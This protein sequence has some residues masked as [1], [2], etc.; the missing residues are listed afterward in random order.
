[1]TGGER[2]R[3]EGSSTVRRVGLVDAP[4]LIEGFP[5]EV[6]FG[7][8][9]RLLSTQ[10]P[11]E[12]RLVL[13]RIPRASALDL[14]RRAG[15]V[16]ETELMAPSGN[17]GATPAELS[18]EAESAAEL[19]RRVAENDPELWR[20][21][22]GFHARGPSARAAERWRDELARRGLRLRFRFRRPL[23]EAALVSAAPR[24]SG[25]EARPNGYWHTLHT[26]GVA[27][28]FPFV[29]EA[30]TE[31]GGVLVGLLLEDAAPVFLDRFRHASFSWGV[32]G[33][34]GSGKSFFA[35][36]AAL[37]T[38]WMRP[39]L[40]LV[41]LD[42]LGEF[43]PLVRQL[44]GTV[45]SLARDGT[46]R[47]NPL[48]PATTAGD[49]EEKAARVGAMLRALFPSL[50]DEEVATLDS[51]LGATLRAGGEPT[52][53]DLRSAVERQGTPGRL[54]TLLE[55]FRTGSLRYLN[56]PSTVRWGDGPVAV[57][58]SGAPDS[59]LAFHLAYVLD[60]VLGRL[61]TRPGPKLVVVDEA[62]LLARDPATAAFL[63]RLVRHARHFEGGLLL[64]SQ[65]PDDFLQSESGRSLLRNLRATLFL[66]LPEVSIAAREFFHLTPAE[67]EWLPRA[68][69][70]REAGYSEGLLRWG[71]AHLPVAV[72]ASTPEY[73]LLSG[74]RVP[75]APAA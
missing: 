44:G 55:L 31:P 24:L 42:P 35:S 1:M 74:A 36:L 46:A 22:L 30:G 28:F 23:Y 41:F 51:A 52:F 57:D 49:L 72:I 54:P 63:D 20:V 70:P 37:R 16:A 18:T 62:H 32:F 50:H 47:L 14:L 73:E 27:A 12:L 21:G 4:L 2:L 29:E 15:A 60:A 43:G 33:A 3:P 6:P 38:R 75:P 59:Q 11:V 5:P 39:D 8:V 26:D 67:A 53:D 7:V 25:S 68:R 69:L 17:G 9:G 45:I 58:L 13:H 19:A 71:P 48:D 66:R 65:N 40:D 56:G 10:E 34:T 64:L 61:R